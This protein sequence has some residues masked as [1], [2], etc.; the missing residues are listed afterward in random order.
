VSVP[1]NEVKAVLL[2]CDFAQ[3]VGGKLYI[4]GGGISKSI[5]WGQPVSMSL[6]IKL[7]VPWTLANRKLKFQLGLVTEDGHPVHVPGGG[8]QIGANGQFEVGRPLGLT[9]GSPLDGSLAVPMFG[10]QLTHGTYRWEL[11]IDDALVQT[12]TFEVIPPPP[13]FVIPSPPQA[14]PPGAT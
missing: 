9:P 3:E 13:G 14:K 5:S 4:L 12:A 10:M 8:P 7:S 1:P 11:K 6:A 2:L